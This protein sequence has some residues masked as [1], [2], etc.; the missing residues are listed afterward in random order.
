LE[1]LDNTAFS[2]HLIFISS[3]ARAWWVYGSAR[4]H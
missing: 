4:G 2:H 3:T 1:M